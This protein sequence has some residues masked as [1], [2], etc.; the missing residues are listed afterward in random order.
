MTNTNET[1]AVVLGG[2]GVAGIAW[3]MGVLTALLEHGID[4][5]D[6]DLVIG[7]SAG[8]VVGTVLRF[9][10]VRHML[11]AQLRK[12][13]PAETDM[14]QGEFSHFST[15][16]FLNMMAE[17]ARGPGGEQEA[18]ARLGKEARTAGKGLSE[19]AW[20]RT[21][22]SLLPSQDWPSKAL[23][24][25]AV[26]A[27]DGAF[28]VFDASSRAELALAVAASCSV[29]GAWPPVTI[30]GAP[31][32]DGGMRSATNADLAA[33]CGRVL[34]LSC[35]PEA[36][37]SPFGPTLPQV[38]ASLEGRTDTFLIEADDASLAAF[39]TNMLLR[40]TRRPAALAG[41]EQGRSLADAVK[42]FWDS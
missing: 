41:Q 37:E 14:E 42:R 19:E 30:A 9:G 6:A 27:D 23:K 10:V 17:A 32:M 13:D 16:Q 11:E 28:T 26:N 18:R 34:V 5:N 35:A 2:G 7:T 31:Y 40:S 4:L 38:L 1:R 29:P 21:I 24:V 36:P 25:T 3:E 12:D 39:G 20:V 15:E 8:S 22:R 33:D